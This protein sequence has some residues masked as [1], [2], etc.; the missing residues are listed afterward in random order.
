[1]WFF[2]KKYR[3]RIYVIND[4]LVSRDRYSK[5]NR[6]V[7]ALNNDPN[8]MRIAKIKSLYD[9]N[10]NKR[11]KLIPIEIYSCLR[12]RSGVEKR[13]YYKTARNN[14]I[15]ENKMKKT[16]CRLNKRDMRRIKN[17]Y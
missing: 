3:G 10:G 13:V 9:R 1:M 14:P 4:D 16:R 6:R 2:K 17:I 7:V 5:R 15:E 12:K 11:N 8:N